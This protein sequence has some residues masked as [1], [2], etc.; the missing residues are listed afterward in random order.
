M[1]KGLTIGTGIRGQSGV[2]LSL[3]GDHPIYLNQGEVPIGGRGAAGRTPSTT[4]IDMHADYPVPLGS[5]FAER[6][7]LKLAMDMFNVTNSQFETGR[8]QYLQTGAT[9]VGAPP[10][11]NVDYGRPTSFQTPFYARGS[12]RFEF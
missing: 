2:P 12:V 6:Y 10:P 8:V 11:L 9:L 4:Q 3:L 7:K 1:A 5:H